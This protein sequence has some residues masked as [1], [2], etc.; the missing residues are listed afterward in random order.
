[1]PMSL[2][3]LTRIA[4]PYSTQSSYIAA[5]DFANIY[6]IRDL[7][8]Q[9]RWLN[10]DDGT[11]FKVL[12]MM[13]NDVPAT[14]PVYYWIEANMLSI[15]STVNYGAGY[16]STATSIV[17]ADP[18]VFIENHLIVNQRTQ[19]LM[20][21]THV[22]TS[23]S[24]LTVTRGYSG[25]TRAAVTNG[26]VLIGLGAQLPEKADANSGTGSVPGAANFNY[27]SRVSQTVQVSHTQEYC[28]MIDGVGQIEWDIV[29]AALQLKRQI[30]QA[31][32]WNQRGTEST[33]DGTVYMTDGFLNRIQDNV[34]NCGDVNGVLSWKILND[35][36]YPMFVATNAS[37]VKTVFCGANLFEGLCNIARELNP[38][39]SEYYLPQQNEN[40][41]AMSLRLRT[42]Q[43][44]ELQILRDK[45]GFPVELGMGGMGIV[46]DMAYAQLKEFNNEP[47]A[48]RRDIQ[49]PQAHVRKDEL[50]G[51]FSLKLLH[52]SLHGVIRGAQNLTVTR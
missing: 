16:S 19:E 12:S 21:C 25:S 7:D 14:Q 42:T 37:P 18:L 29:N 39:Q 41:G 38:N 48:W 11:F 46:V 31:L 10:Q 5:T 22:D 2:P 23:T 35:W 13:A 47:L 50:W 40:F 26:D 8:A 1:M 28:A 32:I 6:R 51:S 24:T 17:V 36:L 20:F 52:P 30:N 45:F 33:G 3:N 4:L 15:Y 49:L 43:G 27:I 34:L 44:G 9:I